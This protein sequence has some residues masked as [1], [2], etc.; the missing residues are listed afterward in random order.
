MFNASA[1]G[2]GATVEWVSLGEAPL[3]DLGH[4]FGRRLTFLRS[5]FCYRRLPYNSLLCFLSDAMHHHTLLPFNTTL[6]C[7]PTPH[8]LLPSNTT[9]SFTIQYHT[10]FSYLSSFSYVIRKNLC[11]VT[12]TGKDTSFKG[13]AKNHTQLVDTKK[14]EN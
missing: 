9:H 5:F 1:V 13:K 6:F 14:I 10:L 7:H 3:S 4:W 11:S 2:A 12:T 8:T